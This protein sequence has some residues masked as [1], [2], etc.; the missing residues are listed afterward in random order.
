MKIAICGL[1]TSENLGEWLI[2]DG[3]CYLIKKVSSESGQELKDADFVFV[4]INANKENVV[5]S[6]GAIDR[7]IKNCCYYK[8]YGIPGEILDVILRKLAGKITNKKFRNN[9]YKIRRSIWRKSTNLGKRYGKYYHEKFSDVD[10]IVVDGA[11]L[12]EYSTNE[13]Q[14]PLLLISEYGE[15]YNIPVIYNAIGS[16]GEYDS[17]DYRCKV[18][19]KALRSSAVKYISARDNLEAVKNCAGDKH[20]VKLLADA[21]F[22]TKEAYGLCD[23]SENNTVVSKEKKKKIGIGLIRGN[24]LLRY[25]INFNEEDWI[26]LFISVG[27]ELKNRGYDFFYFTNGMPVDYELGKKV[28][29]KGDFS[30]D[31]LI[32]RPIKAID[33][34]KTISDC[35]GLITCR[36]HSSIAS[37]TLKIPS[38]VFSWNKKVDRYMSEIGYRERAISVENFNA[39]YAVDLLEKALLEGISDENLLRMKNKAYESVFGYKEY[40]K[41]SEK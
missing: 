17:E 13:Y 15:K 40:L 36:M 7:R 24:A 20:N 18:L 1:L 3:L 37:M 29:S 33:L 31:K 5:P 41:K 2:A 35:D 14:E 8:K 32:D 30:Q 39:K 19:M 26:Q 12:L 25:N 23:T 6:N 9:I 38:V 11:G 28:I 4:D 16:S 27:R 21:A 10:L 22:Y 34:L